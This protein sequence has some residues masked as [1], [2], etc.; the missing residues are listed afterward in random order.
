M[1]LIDEIKK[2][3]DECINEENYYNERFDLWMRYK[4]EM[5]T[6]LPS[7]A[8]ACQSVG[9][10]RSKLDRIISDYKP[11]PVKHAHWIVIDE[12]SEGDEAFCHYWATLKCSRCGMEREVED[13][14]VPDYCEGCGAKMDEEKENTHD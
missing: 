12:G 14:Y 5:W 9:A 7:D 10:I 6:E 1:E 4:G 11:E 13:D 2:L 8:A 3:R